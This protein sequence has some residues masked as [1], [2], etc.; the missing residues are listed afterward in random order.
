MANNK[1]ERLPNALPPSFPLCDLPENILH[2]V[3]ELATRHSRWQTVRCP[4]DMPVHLKWLARACRCN[5]FMWRTLLGTHVLWHRISTWEPPI[6]NIKWLEWVTKHVGSNVRKL[7]LATCQSTSHTHTPPHADTATAVIS[8]LRAA[9]ALTTLDLGN[10]TLG[11][12]F[13]ALA[14]CLCYTPQLQSLYLQRC[15]IGPAGANAL[16]TS[17][18]HTTQLQRIHLAQNPHMGAPGIAAIIQALT[19]ATKL[20]MLQIEWTR[21]GPQP[22]PALCQSLL[23]WPHLQL[24]NT[25]DNGLGN[26]GVASILASLHTTTRLTSLEIGGNGLTDETVT[27]IAELLPHVPYL[28]HL[29]LGTAA[30]GLPASLQIAETNDDL[31]LLGVQMLIDTLNQRD[32]ESGDGEGLSLDINDWSGLTVLPSTYNKLRQAVFRGRGNIYENGQRAC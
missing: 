13:I 26:A 21:C 7:I 32:P 10:T 17:L 20:T 28:H 27:Q 9:P 3:F 30:I 6:S 8:V 11:N 22:I 16:A 24:L 1:P 25:R 19:G 12:N 29:G 31:T 18:S 2:I 5:H 23:R 14:P 15:D 4:S